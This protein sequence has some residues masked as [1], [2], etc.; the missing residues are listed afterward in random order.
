MHLYSLIGCSLILSGV[1]ARKVSIKFV[2]L[3]EPDVLHLCSVRII[4]TETAD[5]VLNNATSIDMSAVR[6]MIN[7]MSTGIPKRAEDLLST[8]EFD[9]F[10]GG[11]LK[12]MASLLPT[13]SGLSLGARADRSNETGSIPPSVLGIPGMDIIKDIIMREVDVKLGRLQEHI[14]GRFN[15]LEM[16]LAGLVEAMIAEKDRGDDYNEERGQRGV[17]IAR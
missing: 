8:L 5:P 6:S 2:S 16:H 3:Q 4:A 7:S 13:F 12:D 17:K 10:G 14:D 15:R 9:S 11:G 1:K